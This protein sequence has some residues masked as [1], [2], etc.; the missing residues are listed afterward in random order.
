MAL[1]KLMDQY[2]TKI[3]EVMNKYSLAAAHE[4]VW[5]QRV[6]INQSIA[7]EK[8]ILKAKIL[9]RIAKSKPIATKIKMPKSKP[10][11]L[12]VSIL[13]PPALEEKLPIE[14]KT[15]EQLA[16]QLLKYKGLKEEFQK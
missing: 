9:K 4:I 7:I 12:Q 15:S 14:I 13:E 1:N 16:A 11:T 5:I 10:Q 8:K 3:V 2:G 6:H